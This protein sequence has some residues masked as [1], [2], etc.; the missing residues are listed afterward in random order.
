M[1]HGHHEEVRAHPPP[2]YPT[3]NGSLPVWSQ[4]RHT[5]W[6]ELLTTAQV[7]YQYIGIR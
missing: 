6:V 5:K 7:A 3:A 2:L 4:S 1:K